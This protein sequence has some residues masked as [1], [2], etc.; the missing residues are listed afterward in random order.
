MRYVGNVEKILVFAILL[1][2][3]LILA[4]AIQAANKVEDD[5]EKQKGGSGQ[6]ATSGEDQK[7]VAS[8]KERPQSS[9]E[10]ARSARRDRVPPDSPSGDKQGAMRP[11]RRADE[12]NKTLELWNDRPLPAK[13]PS[14]GAPS[15]A[16]EAEK[17]K[18]EAPLVQVTA[19]DETPKPGLRTAPSADA[20]PSHKSVGS[21]PPGDVANAEPSGGEAWVYVVQRGDT[22]EGIARR[23]YGE[24]KLWKE[25]YS[26]NKEQLPD[27]DRLREGMT[28]RLKQAPP[29]GALTSV[30]G[31]MKKAEPSTAKATA[32]KEEGKVAESNAA[33]SREGS[34]GKGRF[35]RITGSDEHEVQRS[36][37]L[38]RIALQHYGTK[39]AWALI[40]DANSDRLLDKNSL[41]VGQ[42]L[43]LPAN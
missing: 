3:G 27:S 43:R 9:D 33:L 6:T 34:S 30:K 20:E 28:L 18:D 4:V 24:R 14:G 38:M 22:L 11:N 35:Q 31:L 5:W 8:A 40:F 29:E 7:E 21:S 12:I 26:S 39:S 25:L 13:A 32:A 36:D 16:A 41:K 37:T 17:S 15:S 23:I 42:R 1:V 19:L 2:I 10:A